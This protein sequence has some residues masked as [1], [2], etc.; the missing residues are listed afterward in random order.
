M[1]KGV[2]MNIN[3][4]VNLIKKVMELKNLSKHEFATGCGFSLSTL[5]NVLKNKHNFRISNIASMA[6][7]MD[8]DVNALILIK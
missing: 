5:Y 2:D 6:K 4:N 1:I 7:F 3:V 8:V